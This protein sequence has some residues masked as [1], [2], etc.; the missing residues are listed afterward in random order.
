[1]TKKEIQGNLEY[2]GKRIDKLRRE[3]RT[4]NEFVGFGPHGVPAYADIT[5][6]EKVDAIL[7]HL[8]VK[9]TKTPEMIAV[10]PIENKPKE[11]P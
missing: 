10:V 2:E 9:V 6:G 11:T 3:V 7:K 4:E 5:I 8:G 1:M